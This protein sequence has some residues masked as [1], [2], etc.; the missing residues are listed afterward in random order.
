MASHVNEWLL[1]FLNER[2]KNPTH[3][4]PSF[5]NVCRIAF[6]GERDTLQIQYWKWPGMEYCKVQDCQ[7]LG[8][9][10]PRQW[11]VLS[12]RWDCFLPFVFISIPSPPPQVSSQ[13]KVF[14]LVR[15]SFLLFFFFFL[16]PSHLGHSNQVKSRILYFKKE[17]LFAT[18]C[19]GK[20]KRQSKR[21]IRSF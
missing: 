9:F 11:S 17:N 7:Q 10:V 19:K 5:H 12:C 6:L 15:S 21:R 18:H 13:V 14:V 4:I 3:L 16:V 8:F 20:I 1:C 2:G